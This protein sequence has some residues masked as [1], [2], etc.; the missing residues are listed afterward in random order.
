VQADARSFL[1]QRK[2]ML[3]R[4]RLTA[5]GEVKEAEC[6]L[7]SCKP[8]VESAGSGEA[9]RPL[10]GLDRGID[11]PEVRF[12]QRSRPGSPCLEAL[13]DRLTTDN[14]GSASVRERPLPPARPQLELGEPREVAPPQGIAKRERALVRLLQLSS[15][16]VEPVRG[17]KDGTLQVARAV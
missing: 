15:R 2:Q 16:L 6:Q 12:D 4:G 11:V 17:Q 8:Q 10:S 9:R 5:G 13:V 1:E 7:A 3:E 14:L